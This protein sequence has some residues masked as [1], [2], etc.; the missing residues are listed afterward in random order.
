[1][2]YDHTAHVQS[3]AT[4]ESL[5]QLPRVKR[6]TH[7]SLLQLASGDEESCRRSSQ[8]SWERGITPKN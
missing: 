3:G 7:H 5:L 6:M 2:N 8:F 1:M 4:F